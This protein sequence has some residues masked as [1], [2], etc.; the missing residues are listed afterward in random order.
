MT[1]DGLSASFAAPKSIT[2]EKLGDTAR[3]FIRCTPIK[4]QA[5]VVRLT[6]V[7]PFGR[8]LLAAGWWVE[9]LVMSGWKR[10]RGV[11]RPAAAMCGV[12][13]AGTQFLLSN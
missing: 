9:D 12:A 10:L 7:F 5:E 6:S 11:L 2:A 1:R 3:T 4:Y 13:F 8:L